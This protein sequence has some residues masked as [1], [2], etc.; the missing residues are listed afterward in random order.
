MRK[1]SELC[2]ECNNCIEACPVGAVAVSAEK[3]SCKVRLIDED[4]CIGCHKCE[5][6][7][8]VI[9]SPEKRTPVNAYAAFSRLEE[10][11]LSASA[12][13]FYTLARE[14]I[15]RG[16]VVLGAAF[17][18]GLNVRNIAVESMDE[19][20]R[21]QGSKYVKSDVSDSYKRAEEALK[22]DRWVLYSGTPCQ[23]AGL[24]KSLSKGTD[25]SKL[26]TV[27]II[28][29]GTPPK[30]AFTGFIGY[31]EKKHKA[32]VAQICFR[33][34]KYGHKNIG[35]IADT[36]GKKRIITSADT[37]YYWLFSKGMIF[38][39]ACYSCQFAS[40]Q[41][42]SDITAGDYWGARQL[43]PEFVSKYGLDEYSAISAVMVNTPKGAELLSATSEL[44]TYEVDY[45]KI[46]KKNPQLD[47]PVLFDESTRKELMGYI[48]DGCY[49]KAE[50]YFKK[51]TNIKKYKERLLTYL[52]KK[53]RTKL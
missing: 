12:G 9:N 29:H 18:E 20:K 50:Q 35:Y 36:K 14:I 5:K 26:I 19:L 47:H 38:N 45:E 15:E 7:C 37:S 34:K 40:A 39:E 4:K 46:R 1:V 43:S 49:E 51:H 42:V 33:D 27:D 11:R 52:P 53:I 10:T 13:V 41:R 31:Y 22:N 28:C 23:I 30:E 21:L 17:D 2:C 44:V 32:E 25:Q 24:L 6:V 48:D 8:P 16:G 3:S